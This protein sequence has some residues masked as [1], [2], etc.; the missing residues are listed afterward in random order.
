MQKLKN[1]YFRFF[2]FAH[3]HCG[4]NSDE[5]TD[6]IRL[7]NCEQQYGRNG[8]GLQ[9]RR[10]KQGTQVEIIDLKSIEVS[11]CSGCRACQRNGHRCIIQDDMTALYHKFSE[12]EAIVFAS[13]LYFW[14]I[15]GR[16]KCFIDRLYAVS[17]NDRYPYKKTALIMTAGDER[18]DTFDHAKSYYRKLTDALGWKSLGICVQGGCSG[19]DEDRYVP[20]KGL[21]A[22]YGFGNSIDYE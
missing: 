7:Q 16:V 17:E 21:L 9:N 1:L 6:Y 13:P 3:A 11:D 8:S 19:V 2:N 10:R 22:A 12:A 20:E 14:T 18:E 4:G 5:N 15:S